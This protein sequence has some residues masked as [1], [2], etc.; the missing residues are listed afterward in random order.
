MFHHLR[1]ETRTGEVHQVERTG[2]SLPLGDLYPVPPR[3]LWASQAWRERKA[4]S[5]FLPEDSDFDNFFFL[6]CSPFASWSSGLCP[7][8]T[9][10]SQATRTATRITAYASLN[11][12]V[13]LTALR[14]RQT[15]AGDRREGL[16]TLLRVRLL[17]A[18]RA[19]SRFIGSGRGDFGFLGGG[20]RFEPT[21]LA[22]R[23]PHPTS[24]RDREWND[25][26]E[27]GKRSQ[28]T[29]D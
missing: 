25:Q 20:Q 5:Y 6:G 21:R 2:I 1:I 26:V 18:S 10:Y 22:S 9:D 16:A 23:R 13:R 7:G 4:L 14:A 28:G 11:Q 8:K 17:S 24:G 12:P 3:N 19:R 27:L 15:S 29:T